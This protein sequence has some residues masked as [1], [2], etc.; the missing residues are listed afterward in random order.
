M[1]IFRLGSSS[2]RDLSRANHS[3]LMAEPLERLVLL[4]MNRRFDLHDAQNPAV[5]RREWRVVQTPPLQIVEVPLRYGQVFCDFH[6]M[7]LR[8]KVAMHGRRLVARVAP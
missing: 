7:P 1:Y 8:L 2:A 6:P 3:E 5:V 4:A